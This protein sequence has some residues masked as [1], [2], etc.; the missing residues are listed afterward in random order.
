[1]DVKENWTD[2]DFDELGWHDCRLYGIV[3]PD[4]NFTL[5]FD[6]D[7]IFKWEKVLNGF[8]FWISPCDL[9][10]RDI[11][12]LKVDIDYKDSMLMFVSELKRTNSRL[13]PNGKLMLWDYC[14]ECDNGQITFSS[15]GFTQK[16]R[17]QPVLS[18][19]QD[20]NNRCQRPIVSNIGLNN[21]I[22]SK[23]GG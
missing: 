21:K 15:S 16:I 4:E 1:M 14:V 17:L 20:L 19:T 6:L 12:G 8:N 22:N 23:D 18:E 3:L 9:V 13:S 7:Y 2:S 10:F 5:A 11:S